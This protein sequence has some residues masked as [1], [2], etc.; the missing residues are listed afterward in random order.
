MLST[1]PLLFALLTA[2]LVGAWDH[3]T[4]RM[5]NWITL[6]SLALAVGYHVVQGRQL[7]LLSA[8]LGLCLVGGIPLSLFLLTKG[9]AI[10]GGDVKA[11]GAL[12]AWLGPGQ[13]LEVALLSFSL[14]AAYALVWRAVR[15][16]LLGLLTRSFGLFRGNKRQGE[17]QLTFLRFGLALSAGTTISCFA[18]LLGEVPWLAFL[19]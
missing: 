3:R 16:D 8:V 5:P 6:P 13:G 17:E 9:K 11:L 1:T 4:G 12:G 18:S 7:G 19:L 15:G 2:G 10:G 14:L